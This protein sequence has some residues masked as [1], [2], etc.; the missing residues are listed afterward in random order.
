MSVT[1]QV[2]R[3]AWRS[4]NKSVGPPSQWVAFARLI[5]IT[6]L[7]A[8]PA[9]CRE[10]TAALAVI[11]DAQG[12]QLNHHCKV[13]PATHLPRC[14]CLEEAHTAPNICSALP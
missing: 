11:T 8:R 14:A 2:V 5:V 3:L 1:E 9:R 10:I 13:N 7:D 4:S 12:R 6:G